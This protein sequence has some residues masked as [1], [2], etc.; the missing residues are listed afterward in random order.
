MSLLNKI[1]DCMNKKL[2]KI[3]TYIEQVKELNEIKK[4]VGGAVPDLSTLNYDDLVRDHTT[5]LDKL[6]QKID[7][8]QKATSTLT[9]NLGLV[10]TNIDKIIEE[11][12]KI[13]LEK[14][15][16]TQ[17]LG[18]KAVLNAKNKEDK[19]KLEQEKAQL[20]AQQRGLRATLA[21]RDDLN[22]KDKDNIL[23]QLERL[24]QEIRNK[25][26]NIEELTEEIRVK[27]T[28]I[29]NLTKKLEKAESDIKIEKDKFIVLE[30]NAKKHLQESI[31]KL[32]DAERKLTIME[33]Q[34]ENVTTNTNE[35][36]RKTD[37]T[38]ASMSPLPL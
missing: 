12:N 23:Q 7:L 35:Q 29:E 21:S 36:K 16:V 25:N 20:E 26:K 30:R 24:N 6:N 14:K 1:N 31:G 3:N 37:Q 28:E 32:K 17:K 38:I 2:I 9:T 33:N 10:F 8:Q 27:N 13:T 4:Q 22:Q 18:L 5:E 11:I 15:K 34:L 19:Q